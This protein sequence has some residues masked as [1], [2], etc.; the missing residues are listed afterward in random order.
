M[1]RLL[2][3]LLSLML[4]GLP[5]AVRAQLSSGTV[6]AKQ[7]G[8]W[9]V[10]ANAGTGNQGV[11]LTQVG[12]TTLTGANVVDGVNTAFRINCVVGC[13]VSSFAD[14]AAFTFGTTPV[15]VMGAVV[16]DTA[17]NAVTENSGGAPRMSAQRI[18]YA[19]LHTA[20]G[21]ELLG[22]QTMAASLPVVIASNQSSMPVTQSGA[23]TV[24]PGNTAN[25]TPWLVVQGGNTSYTTGQQ[26]VTATATVL[27]TN[28]AKQVCVKALTAN[29]LTVYLG[30]SG[31]TTAT[32]ME[33]AAGD[34]RCLSVDNSNRV[35]VIAS[36][37]G[38]SVSFD[39]VN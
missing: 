23:W 28:T 24:Q 14:N 13:G 10:T 4:L 15:N 29:G 30:P 33:L 26:A 25:T 1:K 19:N 32:G 37:T 39:V 36:S 18:L 21:A 8:T 2:A 20:A 16:D 22:Q 35:F 38:S 17:T 5:A 3:T 27:P 31:V 34:A 11:N 12:G 7:S 9:T 6:N